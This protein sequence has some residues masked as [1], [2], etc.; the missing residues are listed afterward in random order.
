MP[1][2]EAYGIVRAQSAGTNNGAHP[3]STEESAFLG[4]QGSAEVDS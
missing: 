3:R 4:A 2:W 1:P